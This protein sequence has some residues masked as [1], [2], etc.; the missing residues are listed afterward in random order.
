MIPVLCQKHTVC[1]APWKKEATSG[2][3]RKVLVGNLLLYDTNV[4][5]RVLEADAL[6]ASRM[7]RGREKGETLE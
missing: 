6:L 2:G 5:H 4:L 7:P 3:F 1:W